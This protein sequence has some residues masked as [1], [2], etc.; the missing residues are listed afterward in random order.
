MPNQ[1]VF[2]P[3]GGKYKGGKYLR[4]KPSLGGQGSKTLGTLNLNYY[5]SILKFI[6]IR[7]YGNF[8]TN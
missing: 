3:L 6:P 5:F 4:G 1:R 8:K 2:S 7:D